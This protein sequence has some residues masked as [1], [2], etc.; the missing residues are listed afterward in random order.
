MSSN[1]ALVYEYISK[2]LASVICTDLNL[3]F[4]KRRSF[5]LAKLVTVATNFR[6][7]KNL[8]ADCLV[9]SSNRR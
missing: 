7:E 8:A 9:L 6:F 1:Q 2:E 3:P 4:L 5:V